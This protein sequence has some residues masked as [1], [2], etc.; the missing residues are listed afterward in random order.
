MHPCTGGRLGRSGGGALQGSQH[1]SVRR[2]T[3]THAQ[4]GALGALVEVPC[5]ARNTALS[6][7]F[8]KWKSEPLVILKW[9]GLQVRG[10]MWGRTGWCWNVGSG[11]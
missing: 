8:E 1:R 10:R 2:Y 3:C 5:E 9:L 4:V 11:A 6:E 7:F